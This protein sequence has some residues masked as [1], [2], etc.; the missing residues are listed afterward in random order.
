MRL[1]GSVLVAIA[2]LFPPTAF[3]WPADCDTSMQPGFIIAQGT[4][5][6]YFYGVT[7]EPPTSAAPIHI[8]AARIAF[9]PSSVSVEVHGH[10]ID[11]FVAGSYF[12]FDP[13]PPLQCVSASVGTLPPGTYTVNAA[14]HSADMQVDDSAPPITITIVEGGGVPA[15]ASAPTL[16]SIMLTLLA[17]LLGVFGYRAMRGRTRA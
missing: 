2:A 8:D 13:P 17:G 4:I 6:S 9:I 7:P 11:L 15:P 14:F 1:F 5:L 12:G 16:S 3:A 10:E